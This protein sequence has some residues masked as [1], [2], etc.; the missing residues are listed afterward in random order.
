M[1]GAMW[2]KVMKFLL[3]PIT[4]SSILTLLKRNVIGYGQEMSKVFA[5]QSNQDEAGAEDGDNDTSESDD[6]TNNDQYEE[7]DNWMLLSRLNQH[8]EQSGDLLGNGT[9]GLR[10]HGQCLCSS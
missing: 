5:Q 4:Y 2:Q 3:I 6:G 1:H 10:K 9:A 8:Y 7:T